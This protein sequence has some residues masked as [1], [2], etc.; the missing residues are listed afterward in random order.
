M[1]SGQDCVCI[2]QDAAAEQRAA[3][4]K[5]DLVGELAGDGC[6]SSYDCAIVSVSHLKLEQS[7]NLLSAPLSASVWTCGLGIAAAMDRVG[8]IA[9][10]RTARYLVVTILKRGRWVRL[11]NGA[12]CRKRE[13]PS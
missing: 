13:R 10:A 2:D 5:G 12:G 9:S 7:L 6:G 1:G 4:K 11:V 3:A 8:K